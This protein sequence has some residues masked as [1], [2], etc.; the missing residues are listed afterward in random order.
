MSAKTIP[1]TA[2]RQALM[3]AVVKKAIGGR[4]VDGKVLAR[5]AAYTYYAPMLA[6]TCRNARR[7]PERHF[8]GLHIGPMEVGDFDRVVERARS[9]RGLQEV[10]RT[11]GMGLRALLAAIDNGTMR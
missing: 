11:W 5:V 9:E 10:R 8:P 2:V 7:G 4:E 3:L 6:T 1:L